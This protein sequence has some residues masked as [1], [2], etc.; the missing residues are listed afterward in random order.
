MRGK[1]ASNL[2]WHCHHGTLAQGIEIGAGWFAAIETSG[3]E[4][5]SHFIVVL[6]LAQNSTPIWVALLA[7]MTKI[8]T[9]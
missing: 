9:L 1:F 7:Q 4:Y 2:S 5:V 6:C 8:S 3:K